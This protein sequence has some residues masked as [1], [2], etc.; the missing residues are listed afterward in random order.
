[1]QLFSD[2]QNM[3]PQKIHRGS[4]SVAVGWFLKACEKKARAF[5][6]EKLVGKLQI[7]TS[8]SSQ[9]LRPQFQLQLCMTHGAV[10]SLSSPHASP[11]KHTHFPLSSPLILFSQPPILAIIH[12]NWSH[13]SQRSQENQ[14]NTQTK[15]RS[16][17]SLSPSNTIPHISLS[18]LLQITC[19]DLFTFLP[20]FPWTK[21]ILLSY[22]LWTPAISDQ[23]IHI[24]K[25]QLQIL[26]NKFY[27]NP[28]W[29]DLEGTRKK[30]PA[31]QQ[32]ATILSYGLK[33]AT[34]TKTQKTRPD[35]TQNSSHHN[36]YA[37]TPALKHN[38]EESEQYVSFR[39]QE[40]Y[41]SRC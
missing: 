4:I 12:E 10:T 36:P 11:V 23:P 35:I 24:S 25:C 22:L 32:T 28:R 3:K 41:H 21:Q 18:A 37:Q 7:F 34:E 33:S 27:L 8:P 31:R 29:P 9:D 38:Q 39:S 15:F 5:H 20:P 17:L 6:P 16:S 19:Q 2:I 26:R 13:A 14:E 40:P 30:S 1:M